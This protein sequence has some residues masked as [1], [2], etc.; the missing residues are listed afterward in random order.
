M[1]F[2]CVDG[3]S[4]FGV[5]PKPTVRVRKV[6]KKPFDRLNTVGTQ[7][8]RRQNGWV[9]EY[10]RFVKI[11]SA[12]ICSFASLKNPNLFLIFLGSYRDY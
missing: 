6:E 7:Y 9:Y 4:R 5:N 8:L 12:R 11:A 2:A 3:V 1:L 10:C